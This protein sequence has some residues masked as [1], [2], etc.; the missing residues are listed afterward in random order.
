MQKKQATKLKQLKHLKASQE[1]A[2]TRRGSEAT[3]GFQANKGTKTPK[4][5]PWYIICLPTSNT[6]QRSPLLNNETSQQSNIS[7]FKHF[8]STVI[9]TSQHLDDKLSGEN[10]FIAQ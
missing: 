5:R 2:K 6:H 9:S 8:N 7:I 10:I 3:K 1:R 4:A